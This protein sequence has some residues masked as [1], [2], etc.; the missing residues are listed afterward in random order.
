MRRKIQNKK[1]KNW[2]QECWDNTWVPSKR[3]HLLS[4]DQQCQSSSDTKS[5]HHRHSVHH[6]FYTSLCLT[7]NLFKKSCSAIIDSALDSWTA[8]PTISSGL[9]WW[10]NFSNY[11]TGITPTQRRHLASTFSNQHNRNE[12]C[13]ISI[14]SFISCNMLEMA[15]HL[16]HGTTQEYNFKVF[17]WISKVIVGFE[18]MLYCPDDL[19]PKGKIMK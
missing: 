17:S 5:G 3:K 1:K 13:L 14:S 16:P 10:S 6:F 19:K 2:N 7:P 18:E 12:S 9:T 8:T 11:I 4:Q 15:L